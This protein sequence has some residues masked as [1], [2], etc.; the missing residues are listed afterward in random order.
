MHGAAIALAVAT[1]LAEQLGE[2]LV[3]VASLGDR[4]AVR[5]VVAGDVIG[6]SQRCAG[7]HCDR[8][9]A[10]IGVGRSLK[11]SGRMD[12]N[13]RLFEKTDSPHS[14]EHHHQGVFIR[15]HFFLLWRAGPLEA[16]QM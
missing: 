15:R 13:N 3:H 16:S 5:A 6:I 8:F 12:L 9:L 11:L 2:R 1:L 4:V 14:V 7:A 10:N